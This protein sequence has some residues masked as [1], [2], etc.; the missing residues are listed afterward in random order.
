MAKRCYENMERMNGACYFDTADGWLKN[1]N[2]KKIPEL[3]F[4][5]PLKSAP[6]D[7]TFLLH[8]KENN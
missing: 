1:N 5:K 6:A 7:L 4:E 2:F 8:G 3:C